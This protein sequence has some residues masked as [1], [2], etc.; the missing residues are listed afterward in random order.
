MAARIRGEIV[1]GLREIIKAFKLI[2]CNAFEVRCGRKGL[3][4]LSHSVIDYKRNVGG[5]VKK[6]TEG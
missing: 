2:F 5:T 6:I 4:V 1:R 3:A